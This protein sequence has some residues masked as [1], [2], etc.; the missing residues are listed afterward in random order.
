MAIYGL[1]CGGGG[2][3]AVER[4]LADSPG[5]VRAYVNPSTEMAYVEYT[6][7]ETEPARLAQAVERAGFHVDEL[8]VRSGPPSHTRAPIDSGGAAL[9]RQPMDDG[10]DDNGDNDDSCEHPRAECGTRSRCPAEQRSSTPTGEKHRGNVTLRLTLL[11]GFLLLALTLALGLFNLEGQ[12][13]ENARHT[14][15]VSRN[16]FEPSTLVLPAGRPVVLKL[17]N[18]E[19]AAGAQSGPKTTAGAFAHTAVDTYGDTYADTTHRFSVGELGIDVQLAAGQSRDLYIPTMRP[20]TYTVYCAA[21]NNNTAEHDM[22]GT[23]IV[24]D[25]EGMSQ[26]R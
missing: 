13:A 26:S 12:Q 19:T 18:A 4:A 6:D 22:Q 17:R 20:G 10:R 9:T 3:L 14:V 8:Q 7:G 15:T 21:S 23:I 1:A 11:G 25:A 2:A 16:G 24:H 5:V